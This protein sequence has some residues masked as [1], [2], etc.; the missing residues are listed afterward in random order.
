MQ[1]I[2]IIINAAPYGSERCLSALRLATAL[3][4]NDAKPA[5]RIE[6]AAVLQD[7]LRRAEGVV[8]RA[9]GLLTD[10][11]P[12]GSADFKLA[13][14]T[15][16][17]NICPYCSVSC[18]VLIYSTGRQVQERRRDHPHRGR[19][20]QS[21]QP[22]HAVPEGRRPADMV[23]SPNRLKWPEVREAGTNEWKRIS[24]DEAIERIAK[25]MKADRDANF[26]ATNAGRRHRQPLEHH[27]L[28]GLVG[29]T[30]RS[31]LP[32]REGSRV[33]HDALDTQARI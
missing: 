11:S 16:T 23:Q 15:E 18:G 14:A 33:G 29:R 1:N 28:P 13:R 32:D 20:G 21:G 27:R 2:L 8:H 31:R 22:R 30:E 7:L 4:G 10:I 3:A 26:M 5:I 19:S 12:G 17:R 25:H 6:Q 24:W 9:D